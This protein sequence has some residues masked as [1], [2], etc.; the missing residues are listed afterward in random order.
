[1]GGGSPDH[2]LGHQGPKPL[3]QRGGQRGPGSSWE[4]G[5]FSHAGLGTGEDPGFTC[6]LGHL[7]S[8]VWVCFIICKI[9][10]LGV[11]AT[12][13]ERPAPGK[14]GTDEAP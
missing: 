6:A 4:A 10:L 3:L 7:S 1:M 8:H 13:A 11:C 12:P 5:G 9:G 14:H 2:P